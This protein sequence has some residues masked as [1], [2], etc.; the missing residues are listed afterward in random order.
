M[1]QKQQEGRGLDDG[2]LVKGREEEKRR[3]KQTELAAGPPYECVVRY[4]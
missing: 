3:K 4:I 2:W 1:Q